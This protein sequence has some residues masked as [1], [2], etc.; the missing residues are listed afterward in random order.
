MYGH[1]ACMMTQVGSKSKPIQMSPKYCKIL[2]NLLSERNQIRLDFSYES[3]ANP[4]PPKFKNMA[5]LSLLLH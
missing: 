4:Y 1:I 5:H 3:L 2:S